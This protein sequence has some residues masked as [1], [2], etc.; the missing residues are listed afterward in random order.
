MTPAAVAR[1]S[2]TVAGRI[3]G[4]YLFKAALS[5]SPVRRTTSS[6]RRTPT[7]SFPSWSSASSSA[8]KSVNLSK[9]QALD[10]VFGYT[11]MLDVTARGYGLSK[12]MSRHAQCAQRF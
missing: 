5:R 12:N 1:A 11:I 9:A 4:K 10:A 6:F 2:K 3:I 7:R 8:R